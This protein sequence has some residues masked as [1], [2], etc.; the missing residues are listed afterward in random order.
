M[1][2]AQDYP[3]DSSLSPRRSKPRKADTRER[4]K[5]CEAMTKIVSAQA[6]WCTNA[7]RI[8]NTG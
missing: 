2:A 6:P 3:A 1:E 7:Y 5:L 4:N 8:S